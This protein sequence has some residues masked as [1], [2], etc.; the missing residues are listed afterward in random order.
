MALKAEILCRRTQARFGIIVR[1]ISGGGLSA[2]C[3]EILSVGDEVVV[4]LRRLGEV[5]GRIVWVQSQRFG[6]AFEMR[7]DPVKV[8]QPGVAGRKSAAVPAAGPYAP[9]R[10]RSSSLS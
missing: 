2:E 1:N 9:R 8:H 6:M 3:P 10:G 4:S 7:I 5:P